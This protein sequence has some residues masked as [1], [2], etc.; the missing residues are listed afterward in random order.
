MLPDA[1]IVC[2]PS[3]KT[4]GNSNFSWRLAIRCKVRAYISI[5]YT[6][7]LRHG[8]GLSAMLLL[9]RAAKSS[10]AKSSASKTRF[11]ESRL[12]ARTKSAPKPPQNTLH[13]KRA[14]RAHSRLSALLY[15]F[16]E[17]SVTLDCRGVFDSARDE[18]RLFYLYRP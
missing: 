2:L 11:M 14:L 1:L 10:A 3:Q 16:R 4:R 17:Y 7:S 12:K 13:G 9:T 8:N 18:R 15:T 6:D 5:T